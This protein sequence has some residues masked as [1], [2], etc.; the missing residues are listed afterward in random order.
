MIKRVFFYL[1]HA[2]EHLSS[3]QLNPTILER[4]HLCL[5][6]HYW[7]PRIANLKITRDLAPKHCVSHDGKGSL[8]EFTPTFLHSKG[9]DLFSRGATLE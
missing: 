5:K 2:F 1:L 7:H 6:T 4:I 8:R 9:S 3:L